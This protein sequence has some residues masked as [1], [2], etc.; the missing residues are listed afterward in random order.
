MCSYVSAQLAETLSFLQSFPLLPDL[1][2]K[3][4]SLPSPPRTVVSTSAP[5]QTNDK[6]TFLSRLWKLWKP[7]NTISDGKK[8]DNMGDN[9]NDVAFEA[10]EEI[11]YLI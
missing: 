8:V 1:P 3:P 6:G 11:P 9:E 7:L 2:S 10:K 4:T 5:V